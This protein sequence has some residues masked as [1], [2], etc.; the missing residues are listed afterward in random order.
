MKRTSRRE[1]L[2]TAA[3]G[4]AGLLVLPG[5]A[6]RGLSPR[7]RGLDRIQVAQIGCGRMGREDMAAVLKV[8]LARVVAVCDLDSK[9]LAAGK[10]LAE[11]FYRKQGEASPWVRAFADYRELL[12]RRDVDAVVVSTPDHWH[13]RIAIDAALARKHLYVQKPITY[14][15]AEAIALRRA[16]LA[17]EVVLQTGSQQRSEE[18][19]PAFRPACEAVR[20]GRVGRLREVRIGLGVDQPSGKK[21]A[22]MAVPPNL[23]YERWLGA[24]PQQPYM[25]GRVHPQDSLSARPGWITTEDFGLG[26]ITNWGAHHVDVAQWAM[27][28][29]LSGPLA[30]E[31]R[32]EFMIDDLWTVHRGYHVEMDYPGGARVLIDGEF[33]VGLRFEGDE[34]WIFVTRGG[35]DAVRASDPKLLEPL[36]AGATRFPPSRNHYSNWLEA[37]RAGREPVAPIDQAARSLEA[38]Y[39]AWVAMKLRRKL[40]WD[41]AHERFDGDSEA[42]AMLR[43][44]PRKSDYDALAAVRRAGLVS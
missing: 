21:P 28:Q 6:C 34:G 31:A 7:G 4:G 24:A 9:R 25:Q 37:I 27:G 1:F 42:N 16:V 17:R 14:D 8:P 30:V 29:E 44:D 39:V 23:D 22:P 2:A 40:R 5:V 15:V 38:C 36:P 10:E 43:R 18:P 3:R 26:M 33:E 20:N 41:A 11:E 32:A 13:A 12:G 35:A 19:W